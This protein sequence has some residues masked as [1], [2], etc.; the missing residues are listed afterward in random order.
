M[1]EPS[2][3]ARQAEQCWPRSGTKKTTNT[4]KVA[5][6]RAQQS[7]RHRLLT[8]SHSAHWFTVGKQDQMLAPPHVVVRMTPADAQPTGRA[9]LDPQISSNTRIIGLQGRWKG[10]A[11]WSAWPL[12]HAPTNHLLSSTSKLKAWPPP[13]REKRAEP[14]TKVWTFGRG[15]KLSLSLLPSGLGFKNGGFPAQPACNQ[16]AYLS[17]S[18]K[19]EQPDCT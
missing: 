2:V 6:S 9:T 4:A 7:E 16:S 8:N 13:N 1:R 15:S 11:Q 5:R 12:S 19:S 3:G 18:L 14:V 17:I 10:G